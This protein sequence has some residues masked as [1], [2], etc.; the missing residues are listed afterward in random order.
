[1]D[2]RTKDILSS[3]EKLKA[4]GDT[5]T[6]EH[7]KD[8][9]DGMNDCIEI[10]IQ[11]ITQLKTEFLTGTRSIR[12]CMIDPVKESFEEEKEDAGDNA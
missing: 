2:P 1:M 7:M 12:T 8:Y 11:V 10:I 5:E 9:W 3:I 4:D 6:L